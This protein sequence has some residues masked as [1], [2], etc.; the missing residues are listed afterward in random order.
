MN[1]ASGARAIL[2]GGSEPDDSPAA[3]WIPAATASAIR[4]AAAPPVPIAHYD[5]DGT[6]QDRAETATR[7]FRGGGL[8][9]GRPRRSA[10]SPSAST[11]WTTT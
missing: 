7:R 9:G 4:A 11:A 10:A 3:G 5:F 1:P 6:A 8:L 2:T